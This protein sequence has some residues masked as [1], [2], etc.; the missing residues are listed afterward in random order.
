MEEN[1]YNIVGKQNNYI[2][3]SKDLPRIIQ[4]FI[5]IEDH[6]N[7]NNQPHLQEKLQIGN[8]KMI[9]MKK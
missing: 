1:N 9:K 6:T 4:K 8:K 5:G 3:K 2:F 7:S